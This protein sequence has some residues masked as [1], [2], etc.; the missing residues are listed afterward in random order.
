MM[1][2]S[3]LEFL[4]L[5]VNQIKTEHHPLVR[6]ETI[7]VISFGEHI[8]HPQPPPPSSHILYPQQ[9]T[10][11]LLTNKGATMWSSNLLEIATKSPLN[12][13]NHKLRNI[14]INVILGVGKD[15]MATIGMPLFC[16]RRL[17]EN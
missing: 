14:L 7:T 12:I 2:W 5:K 8:I 17:N 9:K 16:D 4:S 6:F 3:H 13:T 15:R 10:V 11:T 1:G